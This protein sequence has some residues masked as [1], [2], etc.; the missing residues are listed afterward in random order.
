MPL[1]TAQP[2]GPRYAILGLL[3]ALTVLIRLPILVEPWGA[4]Q[5][6]FGQVAKGILEG[7]VPYK[8]NYDLTAYG[9][10]FTFAL[11]FKL[12][13]M[14]MVSAHI[15]H[16][17]VSAVTMIL[18]FFLV[19]RLHGRRAAVLAA[20]CYTIFSNGLAF[21]GFGYE[22]KSAW[23][24]YWYLSQREVFMAPLLLGAVLLTIVGSSSSNTKIHAP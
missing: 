13:G 17:L 19:D 9:V 3:L 20:L 15:G 8:D 14:T 2:A 6:G 16:L 7:K 22:N 1:G 23:G 11:F 4:D 24:T 12:F 10:F 5:A 18:V 21:S